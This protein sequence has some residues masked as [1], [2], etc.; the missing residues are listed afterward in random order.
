M[1]SMMC[2]S[3]PECHM[4]V[5]LVLVPVLNSAESGAAFSEYYG[6]P[7]MREHAIPL[8][9]SPTERSICEAICSFGF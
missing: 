2:A 4:I 6:G 5:V 9:A 3:V 7:W 1:A 8:L